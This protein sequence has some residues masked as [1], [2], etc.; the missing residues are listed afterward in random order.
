MFCR[1]RTKRRI[2]FHEQTDDERLLLAIELYE[3][4]IDTITNASP[5]AYPVS[6][7]NKS[8]FKR[9]IRIHALRASSFD[10]VQCIA[11]SV[12]WDKLSSYI[13]SFT[14]RSQQRS[15]S[16]Y[17]LLRDVEELRCCDAVESSSEALFK[18]GQGKGRLWRVKCRSGSDAGL[19]STINWY[20][21]SP[22]AGKNCPSLE[23]ILMHLAPSHIWL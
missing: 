15:R 1:L 23:F 22:E 10:R 3:Y 18:K 7:P 5:L 21:W 2:S 19:R 6:Q 13:S 14:G 8:A 12:N 20:F 11:D 16:H 9:N 17:F 4:P